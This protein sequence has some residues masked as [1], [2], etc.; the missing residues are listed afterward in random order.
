MYWG[1]YTQLTRVKSE[2][3]IPLPKGMSLHQAMGIGT[4]GFTAMLAVMALEEHGLTPTDEREVVVTGATGGLGSIAVAILAK[5]GY[6]VVAS[7]GRAEAYGD[8]LKTLGAADIIEREVLATPTGKPLES[9]RWAGAIDAIGG[10]T[11]ASLLRTM[12]R[13]SSVA[14]CGNAGGITLETTVFPFILRGVNLL[15]IN[16]SACPMARR[17]EAWHRLGH[18]LPPEMLDMM[19][20]T[21]PLEKVLS[22]SPEILQG[23]IRGRIVVD[24]ESQ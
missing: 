2:W 23:K 9:E 4:A 18:D 8:Y 5:L 24:L 10:E 17:R 19:M 11:L 6:Q 22:L 13:V 3:L 1:G 20:Q 21:V 15:G 7:T 16:S 12:A 14:V